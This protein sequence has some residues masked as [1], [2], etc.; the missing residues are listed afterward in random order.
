MEAVWKHRK[1]YCNGRFV[2]NFRLR[3][4]KLSNPFVDPILSLLPEPAKVGQGRNLEQRRAND[5]LQE[6]SEALALCTLETCKTFYALSQR[7]S[8]FRCTNDHLRIWFCV[9]L[10]SGTSWVGEASR[11]SPSLQVT[12]KP[13]EKK[14]RPDCPL[15]TNTDFTST[16][17]TYSCS[18]SSHLFEGRY[19]YIIA[20]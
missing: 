8:P 18:L 13:L 14:H 4:S 2:S 6:I 1:R 11:N 16:A 15:G 17:V 7:L 12:Q 3:T 20:H 10:Q 5:K 9:T 19:M